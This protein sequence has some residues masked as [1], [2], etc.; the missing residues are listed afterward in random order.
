[1]TWTHYN[2]GII[3]TRWCVILARKKEIICKKFFTGIYGVPGWH[4]TCDKTRPDHIHHHLYSQVPQGTVIKKSLC[5]LFYD[6]AQDFAYLPYS[7]V[8]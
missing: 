7:L 6:L 1:M 5:H 4:H 2:T 8:M 3:K